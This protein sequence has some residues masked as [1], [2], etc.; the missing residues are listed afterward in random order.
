VARPGSGAEL[1][2]PFSDGFF[3]AIT[4][5]AV[6]EHL[7]PKKLT[8]LLQKAHRVL[9]PGGISLIT[10]PASWLDGVFR[11]FAKVNLAN[12]ELLAE[13]TYAYTLPLLGWYFGVAGFKM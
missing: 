9:K 12:A 7:G 13:H 10:T 8:I 11:V 6:V 5:L 4:M 3:S 2:L 1:H